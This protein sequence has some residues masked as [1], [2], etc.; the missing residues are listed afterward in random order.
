MSLCIMMQHCF[1]ATASWELV[2]V[3]LVSHTFLNAETIAIH[4]SVPGVFISNDKHEPC[5]RCSS[6][7]LAR[8]KDSDRG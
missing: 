4:G 3:P 2:S 6:W 7:R 5:G 1:D 8:F